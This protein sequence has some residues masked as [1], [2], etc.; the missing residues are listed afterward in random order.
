MD[1]VGF[2]TDPMA[3]GFMQ[4]GLVASVLVGIVSAVM[5][6][7]VV[8]KGLAFIGDA[9][10]HATFPGLVIAYLVGAPLYLGGAIAAVATALAIGFV[11]RRGRLRFDTSV[12]VMFAGTFAFGVLLFSTIKNYVA[13]LLGYLLGNVLGISTGDLVQLAVLGAIVL[14]IVLVIRKELLYATFDPLGAAASGLPVAALEYLLLALLGVTIV[15]SIQAVGIIMVVA[16]LVTPAATAQ[17]LVVRFGQ[18]M[19]L[20]V[21][22]AALSAVA[23]LYLSFYLNLASGASIVLIETLI[24]G[25]ALVLSPRTGLLGRRSRERSSVAAQ[26]PAA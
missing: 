10:S 21:V 7:F 26:T 6:T 5:G 4:R 23:G 3:Y 14:V 15:V 11:S 22:I 19:A 2:L 13:D 8:L 12:G 25:L 20:A 17:L 18:M 1:P 24:F 9:V 16:M